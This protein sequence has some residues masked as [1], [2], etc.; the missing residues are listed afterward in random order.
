VT[1][2]LS[3]QASYVTPPLEPPGDDELLICSSRPT[4]DLVLDL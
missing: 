4:T 2:R 3:G 1:G